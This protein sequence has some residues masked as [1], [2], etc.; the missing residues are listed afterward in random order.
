MTVDRE[1]L[2]VRRARPGISCTG[3]PGPPPCRYGRATAEIALAVTGTDEH[4]RGQARRDPGA[5]QPDRRRATCRSTGSPPP[6]ATSG[7]RAPAPPGRSTRSAT[8]TRRWRPQPVSRRPRPGRLDHRRARH[9]RTRRLTPWP[10]PPPNPSRPN[11]APGRT[12]SSRRT[13]WRR[14]GGPDGRRRRRRRAALP[15]LPAAHPVVA[16]AARRS[17]CSG[18]CCTGAGPR[19]GFGY[20][21]LFGLGFLLPLLVWIGS[22]RRVAAVDRAERCSR[23]CSSASPGAGMARGLAAAG[24]AGVG[25]G[26]RGSPARR[27]RGRV[28][29]GGL[30][31]GRVGFGQPDG[32]LLPLAAIGGEPLLSFV[33]RARRV[34]RSASWCA[35]SSRR[36]RPAAAGRAGRCIAVAGAGGRAAG[37]AGARRPRRA[38]SARSR[39]PRSRATCPRLGLDFNAQRRAVL[40]NHV[41]V[42][43]QLAADVAAG[44]MPQPDLVIWP[45]N[46]SDIDPLRNPDA[47]AQIDRAARAIGVADPG[48]RGAAQPG[49]AD[50]QRTPRWSG[51]RASGSWSATTSAA[52]SRSAS[53]CRGGSSS[54]LFS[55]YVD[56]AGNFVPGHGAGRGRHGRRPGR[57]RDLLGGRVRR[58]GRRQRRRRAPR[59]SPCPATTPPSGCP[60]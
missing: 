5:R 20:G 13:R 35:G 37:R 47:A 3:P 24:R 46:S 34:S 53:T 59:C 44:R 18:S 49:R 9:A 60:R 25:R 16:G 56:R 58:P 32:P 15:Q 50:H 43:E 8:R 36:Q 11:R 10:Y 1:H 38:R 29:F 42:T 6:T 12:A 26:G 2:H 28:P 57:R 52:S 7:T 21:F 14:C 22:S 41:R 23:R 17:R 27:V 51:R 30:P 31:W 40:D 48:R 45:E 54:A 39:S 4:L 55:P 19:A 33:D